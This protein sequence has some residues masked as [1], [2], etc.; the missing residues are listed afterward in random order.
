VE[1]KP[2]FTS[3]YCHICQSR[4]V[5]KKVPGKLM[6]SCEKMPEN[7]CFWEEIILDDTW[8]SDEVKNIRQER[9]EAR[10]YGEKIWAELQ[11]AEGR[12][13]A[14]D[15]LEAENA[16]LKAELREEGIKLG[17][18]DHERG[19]EQENNQ[20]II[21]DLKEERDTIHEMLENADKEY[22]Q[23][24]EERDTLKARIAE[25]E[26]THYKTWDVLTPSSVKCSE[27][28]L[29]KTEVTFK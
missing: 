17:M 21:R 28:G 16:K 11:I 27:C 18:C 3:K 24:V 22:G 15:D 8:D 2:V 29:V 19:V 6:V 23:V 14:D 26:C 20:E 12:S 4:I 1:G 25:L 7:D 10:D 5:I 13:E 9:N